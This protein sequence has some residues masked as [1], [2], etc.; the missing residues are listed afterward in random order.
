MTQTKSHIP[1]LFDSNPYYDDF[2]VDKGFL[3]HL[4]KPGYGIQAR[5]LTQIQSILQNQVERFGS[6][7]FENGSVVVGGE[8][9]EGKIHWIRVSVSGVVDA[10]GVEGDPIDNLAMMVGQDIQSGSMKG[11]VVHVLAGRDGTQLDKGQIVFFTPSTVG[12][13]AAGEQVVTVGDGHIGESFRIADGTEVDAVGTDA[14]LVTV[15]EGFFFVDGFFI[16]TPKQSI[17]PFNSTG[18]AEDSNELRVFSDPTSSV[19]FTV[20]R[21]IVNS[22]EDETLRD[23]A[24]GFYNFNAP[25]SDRYKI[26]LALT[27][28]EFTG[29][30]GDASTLTFSGDNFVE[31]IRIVDGNTTKKIEHADYSALE[32]SLARRTF[33]ES[34]HYTIGSPKLRV[35]SHGT[36]FTPSDNTNKFAVGIDPH[37]S[38]VSGYE[39]ETQSPTFLSV[40]KP[41]TTQTH[42]IENLDLTHGN[43]FV[44]NG[45]VCT[46]QQYGPAYNVTSGALHY[47]RTS[48][49]ISFGSCNVVCVRRVDAEYRAY[50]SGLKIDNNNYNIGNTDNIVYFDDSTGATADGILD[51]KSTDGS[52]GPKLSGHKS[53][54]FPTSGN[55]TI[56]EKGLAGEGLPA[57]TRLAVQLVHI[58]KDVSGSSVT[59]TPTTP[60]E[61]DGQ[62]SG[63]AV[64]N[65]EIAN[66][67]VIAIDSNG[68]IVNLN[69]NTA[70]DGTSMTID[71]DAAVPPSQSITFLYSAYLDY[72]N[73]PGGEFSNFYRTLTSKDEIDTGIVSSEIQEV[74]GIE[75][76]VFTLTKSDVTSVSSVA[77]QMNNG[78]NITTSDVI[79][80]NGQ[81]SYA[82]TLGRVFVPKS[83]LSDTG[84]QVTYEVTVSFYYNE[85]SGIGPVT[86]DSYGEASPE[87]I[88]YDAIPSFTDRD[89]GKFYRL[90]KYIDFR[91][92]QYKT[93]VDGYQ[94]RQHSFG[95]PLDNPNET[96]QISYERYLPR[97]DSVVVGE[98]RTLGVVSGIPGLL[99]EPPQT[100][101]DDMVL[102]HLDIEPYVFDLT[103]DV[104]VRHVDNRRFTMN[105]I[106]KMQNEN[107]L[108]Y[109][110]DIYGK[111][112]SNAIARSTEEPIMVYGGNDYNIFPVTE[113]IM[114]DD[115]TGHAFSDVANLDHNCS[116]DSRLGG[117]RPPFDASAIEFDVS[118]GTNLNESDD[119][120]VTYGYTHTRIV[121]QTAGTETTHPNPYGEVDYLGFVKLKP[122]S[123]FYFDE[124]VAPYVLVN[125]FGEN[126]AYQIGLSSHQVGRSYGYGTLDKE[127]LYH[128]LGTKDNSFQSREVDPSSREYVS[129]VP[130]QTNR[131]PDRIMRT[132][133]NK[134]IDE[135][136]VPYMRGVG[137]TFSAEGLL[138]GSKVYAFFDNASVG[139]ADGYDVDSSTGSVIGHI[140][141]SD[142]AFLTGEKS[143]RLSDR[144][145]NDLD[146]ANTMA[147]TKFYSQGLYGDSDNT[148]RSYRELETRKRSVNSPDIIDYS[149]DR[150]Q[151]NNYTPIYGGIEPLA[152]E[153]IV[154]SS[155]YPYGIYLSKID[156]FFLGVDGSHPITIQLRPMEAGYPHPNK[157]VPLSTVTVQPESVQQD[158]GPNDSMETTFEFSSPVY[159]QSGR[160][161]VCVIT[162][163][164]EYELFTST[165]GEIELDSTGG[166]GP[167]NNK[168]SK[169]AGIGIK[170]G[171][172]FNPINNGSRVENMNRVFMMNIHRCNFDASSA[173]TINMSPIVPAGSY[174]AHSVLIT[175][176]QQPYGSGFMQPVASYNGVGSELNSERILATEEDVLSTDITK[177]T[178]PPSGNNSLSPVIDL[179]R[180]GLIAVHD[181]ASTPANS[182]VLGELRGTAGSASNIAR[183][184]SKR[185]TIPER[186]ANDMLVCL[187]AYGKVKVYAKTSSG[188]ADFDGI[189]W[190][191]LFP[192][193]R[194]DGADSYPATTGSTTAGVLQDYYFR[195][196][197]P[198]ALG[199]FNTYSIKIVLFKEDGNNSSRTTMSYAQD[200]RAIP[201]QSNA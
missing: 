12:S 167:S 174:K 172:L 18:T 144:S 76:V 58:E 111:L 191:E 50:I 198:T 137:I 9:V 93:G 135:S 17:V 68:E 51:V 90:Q 196:N 128:W 66:A 75:Y 105:Q 175:G 2:S 112:V 178:F 139:S 89:S 179:D 5:E 117:V 94:V 164:S 143:F 3:R 184:V 70:V 165:V 54:L 78:N 73:V 38:Y 104:H 28:K 126:N 170:L 173:G 148:S 192:T 74:N 4:F 13:F 36:A 57:G 97:T 71:F 102:Y 88:P 140:E 106:G 59:I 124:T 122:A 98:D 107:D 160:Y 187:K 147:E 62:D 199:N 79:L 133:G 39:L 162:N 130:N 154:D 19:G 32:D 157:V 46:F 146:L 197:T 91:P 72:D 145:D 201:L 53:L 103:R 27:S 131:Y 35:T 41:R 163:G 84:D 158:N 87:S 85:H 16:H 119:G 195:P 193:V 171:S 118:P 37:K 156:L 110:S 22:S 56:T 83:Q 109:R 149:Y 30:F 161:A 15:N 96:S 114:V 6:H 86:I 186:M 115:F 20:S 194:A 8:V 120:I 113:G 25:G 182:D 159:L 65:F 81:R 26:D 52:V 151:D 60:R 134:S 190:V 21:M 127:Y 48:T 189:Q 141:I 176:N 181:K 132:V 82:Y 142:G 188:A 49:G 7:I 177:I 125:T 116:M 138:G 31:L 92:I 63:N 44:I 55:N 168:F 29:S 64:T 14:I 100:S 42:T 95:L 11:R 185:M 40:N 183:Y 10:A 34:G 169:N 47:L 99:G 166:P 155:R 80:D 45:S 123:D 153:I 69:T 150:T 180:I 33:D 1:L 121:G 101:M 77:D 24:S 108:R 67:P 61:W 200:L 23:P 43:Y 129:P 152:Q 136:V